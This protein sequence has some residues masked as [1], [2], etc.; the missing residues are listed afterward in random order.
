MPS[1]ARVRAINLA[2]HDVVDRADPDASGFTGPDAGRYKLAW[3]DFRAQLDAIEASAPGPPTTAL[4]LLAGRAGGLHWSLT[5]DDG[6]VSAL[7][8]GA[9]LSERGWAGQ[10]FVTTDRIGTAGFLDA[11]GIRELHDMGHVIGSHSHTHPQRM[12]ACTPDDLLDEWSVSRARLADVLGA[13][14]VVAAVPGGWYSHEVAV[15]AG[16]A[17]VRALYTSEPVLGASTVDGC[18]VLGRFALLRGSSAG[19]AG[20]LVAGSRIAR[21]RMAARWWALRPIKR[22]GGE[23]YLRLRRRVL[24][25]GD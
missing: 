3:E 1:A 9:E 10:F 11:A 5:F 2:Y 21:L 19:T 6:G 16:A 22:I 12:A 20:A 23:R 14:P 15:A 8:I 4:D 17:G 7:A 13:A 18:L 25:L 24:G